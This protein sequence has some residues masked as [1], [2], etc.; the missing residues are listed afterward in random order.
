MLFNVA[1]VTRCN[2][3]NVSRISSSSVLITPEE[4][5]VVEILSSVSDLLVKFLEKYGWAW[6]ARQLPLEAREWDMSGS[7]A[8]SREKKSPKFE[9]PNIVLAENDFGD[10]GLI[11]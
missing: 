1:D 7:A 3:S 11:H 6:E 9:L 4:F 2:G 10:T 5:V 8:V